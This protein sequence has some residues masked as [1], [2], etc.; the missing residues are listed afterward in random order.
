MADIGTWCAASGFIDR[1]GACRNPDG[2]VCAAIAGVTGELATLRAENEQLRRERDA[3]RTR[4]EERVR[5]L[6]EALRPFAEFAPAA[7][8]YHEMHP[9]FPW[10]IK[11]RT[12]PWVDASEPVSYD[13]EATLTLDH[14]DSA[15]AALGNGGG[16]AG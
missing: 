1:K 5:V 14:F 9:Y 16:D 7:K 6:E 2:C 15:R 10:S 4:Q 13:F 11:V 3:Q 12:T 8:A